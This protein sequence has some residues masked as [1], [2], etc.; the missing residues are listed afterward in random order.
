VEAGRNDLDPEPDQRSSDPAVVGPQNH[1]EKERHGEDRRRVADDERSPLLLWLQSNSLECLYA[2]QAL[3]DS[4]IAALVMSANR[5]KT[6]MVMLRVGSRG[7]TRDG[8]KR[9]AI[10]AVLTSG[11]LGTAGVAASWRPTPVS[12]TGVSGE[13]GQRIMTA[14]SGRRPSTSLLRRIRRGE[15]GGVILFEANV[16][17]L[18]EARQVIGKLQRAAARGGQPRLLIAT[19][20]EGGTVKRFRSLPPRHSAA[21]M[22]RSPN[23]AEREG[24]RTGRALRGVGVNVDLAPVADVPHSTGHFLGSRAFSRTTKRAAAASAAFARGLHAGGVAATGKHFPGLGYAAANTDSADVT[25]HATRKRLRSDYRPFAAL[26]R[27]AVELVMLSNAAY[28][29]LDSARR[30][31]AMS[32]R[33]VQVELRRVVGFEGVTISDSLATPAIQ[34]TRDPYVKVARA[35]TDI[36]LFASEKQSAVAFSRLVAATRSGALSREQTRRATA[37]ILALK[38]S[39]VS[40]VGLQ[41]AIAPGSPTGATSSAGPSASGARLG[42]KL[43]ASRTGWIGMSLRGRRGSVVAVSEQVAGTLEPVSNIRLR[44]SPTRK[45]RALTWRCDRRVR[46]LV[47]T[48]VVAGSPQRATA[49]VRTPSC[50]RRLEAYVRPLRPRA[51][52]RATVR[53]VDKWEIGDLNGEACLTAASGAR[54]CNSFRI[55]TGQVHA[56]PRFEIGR[57]GTWRMEVTTP[58]RQRLHRDFEV[59]GPGERMK[60][61]ATGDSMVQY[62][63]TSLAARLEP[64][65][66]VRS[67]ARVSTGISKPSLLDWVA[68]ARGQVAG[69][70]PDVSVVFIGANDGFP[71]RIHKRRVRCCH[72][73]WVKAY[74]TRARRMM[75]TYARRKRGQVYWLTLP[76][77]RPP[78]WRRIYRAVNAALL[79]AVRP[80]GEEVRLIE[81]GK[82]FTP[83]GRFRTTMRWHGRTVVVRQ[84]DGVHLTPAGAAIAAELIVNK[85]RK[86]QLVE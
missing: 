22:G 9:L 8:W 36:L 54:S 30:P 31:A 43:N 71:L 79:R 78:Q 19:D 62:V 46:R 45:R 55:S 34:R 24:R 50:R 65:V 47:A 11:S 68:H 51:G 72:R 38:A 58:W 61:L 21:R 77:P 41:A 64:A 85:L 86:G 13:I 6:A 56:F 63:D 4:A 35:G 16:K 59:R 52:S 75:R 53:I 57:P 3:A 80:F 20:Q 40:G 27:D 23:L 28:P 42:I 25:I 32:R 26:K 73:A 5:T 44:R 39:L 7:L 76:A 49:A 84:G 48:A 29:A 10:I 83:H 60:L 69:Y 33:I 12:E 82:V 70:R 18:S 14:M 2:P 67:D 81:L 66:D 37:R 15:V 74:A 17:S 1:V